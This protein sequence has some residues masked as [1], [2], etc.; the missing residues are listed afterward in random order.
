VQLALGVVEYEQEDYPAA[1]AN[2]RKARPKLPR[3]ADYVAYY[4]GA[5]RV[6]AGDFEG[7]ARDLEPVHR[8]PA[9]PE[10]G[11][12]VTLSPLLLQDAAR[13]QCASACRR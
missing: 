5:A 11:R 7:V 13:A 2:L 12:W 6:G 10:A 3:I 4:L 1:A 9:S 8:Q